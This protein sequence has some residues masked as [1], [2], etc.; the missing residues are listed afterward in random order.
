LG[1]D[2]FFNFKGYNAN[3]WNSYPIPTRAPYT[4]VLDGTPSDFH[5]YFYTSA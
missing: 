3:G 5:N 1:G 2:F 4:A